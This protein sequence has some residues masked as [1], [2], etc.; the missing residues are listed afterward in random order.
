CASDQ[1]LQ[2]ARDALKHVFISQPSYPPHYCGT[3]ID[4][5]KNPYPDVEWIVQL[6]RMYWW[7][8]LG[9][10]YWHTG[11]EAFAKEWT[12][13]FLDWKKKCPPE[14]NPAWR[15]LE[16]GIR[17]HSLCYWYHYFRDSESFTPEFLSE[18]LAT[19]YDHAMRLA[20]SYSAGSNW[21]LMESEGLAFIAMTFPE[22]KE[23]AAWR[24]TALK[25]LTTELDNQ[26][27][28]D[29]MQKELSFSYH[30]GCIDWFS[31]T[32]ALAELNNVPVPK[33][34]REKIEKMY[35]ILAYAL[36]PDGTIPMFG[37]CWN[38][39]GLSTVRA[40]AALYKRPDLEYVA[41][42]AEK[43]R[44]GAV[45]SA[46]VPP[47]RAGVP[48]A[49]AGET[50]A[51]P[52]ETSVAFPH[53][54]YY[55]F[56]SA[57][58]PDAVWLALK[59]G[60][61]GGWHCQPDNCS[62]ELYAHGAYLMPD[63]GCFIYSGDPPNREWFQATAHHQCLTLDGKN[64]KYAPKLLLWQTTPELTA[65]TVE[66]QSYAGLAHRRNVFFIQKK[67]FLLVDEALG[68]AKGARRL[69]FQFGPPEAELAADGSIALKGRGQ[70][71]LFFKPI[72]E[73]FNAE[74]ETG[75]VAFQYRQKEPRSAFAY[76]LDDKPVFAALLIP[77]AGDAPPS[78]VAKP[79]TNGAGQA[80]KPGD[81][82]L[83]CQI[84]VGEIRYLLRRDLKDKT[85]VLDFSILD[86][87]R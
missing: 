20:P 2:V 71:R 77:Y 81:E 4:W 38:S 53:S 57:W 60:P 15:A 13:Q 75:Q 67:L 65:L 28:A 26:V 3:D 48:P 86:I 72:L 79:P 83:V 87:E 61:N 56:R 50:P 52:A 9:R 14:F 84:T 7:E 55:I 47:A 58:T 32:A 33:D 5:R 64:S 24:E 54:G 63:S 51:V 25:R 36:K 22:F 41:S 29:G 70:A 82:K 39:S 68:D 73:G 80:Y 31:R 45:G 17:G 42:L 34:Y 8:P 59:C 18:Y 19:A 69:H 1:E 6:H 16:I 21:G 11:D 78:C 40:G 43:E 49:R 74:K 85:A 44:R 23:A 66:N 76:N 62:F 10:A 27:L 37:D 12:L 46:G 30:E 35:H